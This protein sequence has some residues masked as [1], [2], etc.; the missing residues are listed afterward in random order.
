MIA[1]AQ[2]LAAHVFNGYSGAPIQIAQVRNLP[3]T[4]L[5]M[6]S[7]TE[8]LNLGQATN[9]PDDIAAENNSGGAYYAAISRAI[10]HNIPRGARVILAGHS[11]GG[12]EAEN[13]VD[14]P[15]LNRNYRFTDVIT[16]GSPKTKARQDPR[17]TYTA[18][19]LNGD[20]VIKQFSFYQWQPPAS[21][22]ILPNPWM[23]DL[24]SVGGH[25]NYQD[26][27]LLNQFDSL[28]RLHGRVEMRIGPITRVGAPYF[29]H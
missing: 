3:R 12:M 14:D 25:N 19:D 6:L 24:S 23:N 17:V 26:D 9:I 5:V 10:R 16:F 2:N 7:G 15:R 4:Y 27:T 28:G 13:I 18:F 29:G 1:N 22:Y 8:L 20:P 11:L 21:V